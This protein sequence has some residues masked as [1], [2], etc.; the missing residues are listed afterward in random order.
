MRVSVEEFRKNLKRYIESREDVEVCR[1]G[2]VVSIMKHR[3]SDASINES[4]FKVIRLEELGS[5][6]NDKAVWIKRGGVYE[7]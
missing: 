3:A 2:K 1:Y 4:G 5:F 7:G 6:L